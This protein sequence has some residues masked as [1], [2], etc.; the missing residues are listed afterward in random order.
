MAPGRKEIV[1]YNKTGHEPA[2]TC[3]SDISVW[4][5]S[6]KPAKF[7]CSANT[8]SLVAALFIVMETACLT[9]SHGDHIA[10]H[11]L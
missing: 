7:L 2:S 6:W 8:A 10:S 1:S 9:R 5:C 3:I 11:T 4:R